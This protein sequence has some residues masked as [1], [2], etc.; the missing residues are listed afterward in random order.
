[1]TDFYEPESPEEREHVRATFVRCGKRYRL[2]A[3]AA[4]IF[5][6]QCLIRRPT[7]AREVLARGTVPNEWIGYIIDGAAVLCLPDPEGREPRVL[8]SV[9]FPGHAYCGALLAACDPRLWVESHTDTMRIALL[10]QELVIRTL[11]REGGLW[12]MLFAQS[13]AALGQ[14]LSAKDGAQLSVKTKLLRKIGYVAHHAGRENLDTGETELLVAFTQDEWAQLI[15]CTRP[16]LCKAVPPL[17]K[18]GRLR[19]E[20]KTWFFRPPLRI[21]VSTCAAAHSK[22]AAK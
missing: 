8:Q 14:R 17:E 7:E 11:N 9:L 6:E 12:Y 2:S 16:T 5:A 20:G 4:R 18:S 3:S 21:H 15:D 10:P 13:A 19:R 1:M 22:S